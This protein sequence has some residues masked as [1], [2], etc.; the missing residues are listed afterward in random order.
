[1]P[2]LLFLVALLGLLPLNQA[3]S[4][5]EP[6]VILRLPG[7]GTDPAK[8]AYDQLPVIAG[9]H[10]IV[11]PKDPELVFQLHSYLAHFDGQFWC[12]WSQGPAVEDEPGQIVRYATSEDGLKWS[13]PQTLVGPPAEGYAYIARGLWVR[14]GQLVALYAHFKGKG[15]FGVNKE[16]RLEASVWDQQRGE[17]TPKGLVFADAINNFPP[18]KL[19]SGE[20]MT[21]RRDS[22]FNVFVLIG[23]LKGLDDWQ[24]FP[25]ASRRA[26]AGFSPD[27]PIWWPQPDGKLTAL[28]RDNG[29]SGR[30]FRSSSDDDGRTWTKPAITNFP[31][32]TSKLF[33]LKTSA[34]DRVLI[35]NANPK[36]GRREMYL[37]VSRDGETFTGMGRLA[38]PQP[39]ATTLQYP[40]AIEHDGKLYIAFS[41]KKMQ[42]EMF[43]VPLAAIARLSG[44]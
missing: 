23:G 40:H 35:S 16:L 33:S 25:V 28:Y 31:N 11:C 2:K 42:I 39:R 7:S 30:L 20:W 21:T 13:E 26:V 19:P 5:E 3:A 37:S 14:D 44:D 1:V 4:A 22:R 24:S 8:I 6:A 41:Q 32:A 18:T 34:G 36:I 38:I 27:E 10:A 29:G 9:E 15:A 17:W 12:M 43:V